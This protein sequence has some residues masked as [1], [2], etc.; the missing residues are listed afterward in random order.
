[1]RD[2]ENRVSDQ[3]QSALLRLGGQRAEFFQSGAD[4]L[5]RS[6]HFALAARLL[7]A[8]AA[9][10]RGEGGAPTPQARTF[11][12]SAADLYFRGQ[13]WA[14]ARKTYL[15]LAQ[16]AAKDDPR[17]ASLYER[18]AICARNLSDWPGLLEL[19]RRARAEAPASAETWWRG[20]EDALEVLLA[21]AQHAEVVRQVDALA[22]D[23]AAMGGE[24]V[25]ARLLELRRRAIEAQKGSKETAERD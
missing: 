19:C 5:A 9:A 10:F 16:T 22:V 11:R 4:D 18:A 2:S 25:K 8:A 6:G 1:M 7:V 21:A 3:A 15:D 23:E 24:A 12:E 14:E 20:T 17:L 13:T